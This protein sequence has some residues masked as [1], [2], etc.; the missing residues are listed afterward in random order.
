MA[1]KHAKKTVSK[2]S[3]S[4][5]VAKRQPTKKVVIKKRKRAGASHVNFGIHG[6]AKIVSNVHK[7][8]LGPDLDTALG[9]DD[10]FVKIKRTSLAKIKNFVASKPELASLSAETQ[11]CDCSPDDPYCIYI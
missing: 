4:A 9:H 10:K 11:H 5:V 1:K 3:K 7:A 2:S 6:I 8:G